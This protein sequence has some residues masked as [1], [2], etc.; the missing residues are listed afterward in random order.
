MS[1]SIL[2][3]WRTSIPL[4]QHRAIALEPKTGVPRRNRTSVLTFV[5]LDILHYTRGTLFGSDER[6]RTTFGHLMR[7]LHCLN[8]TSLLFGWYAISL[9]TQ[10]PLQEPTR[11]LQRFTNLVLI[12]LYHSE[13]HL[14]RIR[15][16]FG[17]QPEYSIL[18]AIQQQICFTI[19]SL[20]LMT[21]IVSSSEI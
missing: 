20:R 18:E 13:T 7:V 10:R 2:Y 8:A 21:A 6:N 14:G 19:V 4:T 15:T 5:A 9:L 3:E 12:V 1:P 16:Y 11:I 17:D